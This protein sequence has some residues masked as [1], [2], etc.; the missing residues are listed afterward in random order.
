MA[1][2][3]CCICR[4]ILAKYKCPKCA[5]EYCLL[6]CF[7]DTR[8]SHENIILPNSAPPPPPVS[9]PTKFDRIAADPVIQTLL[10]YKSLQ[11]H[12]AVLARMLSDSAITNEP[13]AEN[14]RE[15]VNMRL[16]ELRMG[17]TEENELVEEFVQRVLE[18]V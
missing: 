14:R 8:H 6:A 9:P 4:E 5:V 17:G 7:K 18:L 13:V 2:G 15:I 10:S 16:C 1:L 11:V 12:L 3:T